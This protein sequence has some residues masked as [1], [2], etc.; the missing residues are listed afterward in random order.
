MH[1]Q[2]TNFNVLGRIAYY[3]NLYIRV[4]PECVCVCVHASL[5][6]GVVVLTVWRLLVCLKSSQ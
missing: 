4:E 1:G 2:I 3:H 6:E 5:R